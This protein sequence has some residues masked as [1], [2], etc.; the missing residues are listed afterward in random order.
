MEIEK[1]MTIISFEY[2]TPKIYEC[3]E[4]GRIYGSDRKMLDQKYDIFCKNA[5]SETIKIFKI[6][7]RKLFELNFKGYNF[8]CTFFIFFNYLISTPEY[9]K[10]K[11]DE[12]I[13]RET[14]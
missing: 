7:K 10:Q 4:L 6:E 5:S 11:L 3:K 2:I 8:F 12:L 14:R 1:D 13:G 9:E